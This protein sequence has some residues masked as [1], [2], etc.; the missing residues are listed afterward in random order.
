[1]SRSFLSLASLVTAALI[2]AGCRDTDPTAPSQDRQPSANA[3]SDVVLSVRGTAGVTLPIKGGLGSGLPGEQN[4]T[5]NAFKRQD[6]T[7]GGT[8]R[9]RVRTTGGLEVSVQ[10]GRVFCMV[11]M[12]GGMVGISAQ[13]VQR[14][15]QNPPPVFPGLPP[16]VLPDNQGIIIAVQDNGDAT[17]QVTGF[18][19]TTVA[20]SGAI[21][22]NPS[23]F[24]FTP[25]AIRAA[26]LNDLA[27]GKLRVKARH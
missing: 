16:A 1:M 19:N 9:Y 11:D 8:L 25:T 13:G 15:A 23:A 3:G 20:V 12:G 4:F 27:W 6:G 2:V 18:L 5:L 22:A 26:F 7:V 24:G 17:G 10:T 21:C 14:I